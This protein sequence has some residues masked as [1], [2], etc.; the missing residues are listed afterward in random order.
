MAFVSELPPSLVNLNLHIRIMRA[1][2]HKLTSVQQLDWSAMDCTLNW[3]PVLEKAAIQLHD[4][5]PQFYPGSWGQCI[6]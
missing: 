2:E 1:Y 4:I 6:G 3:L 5:G